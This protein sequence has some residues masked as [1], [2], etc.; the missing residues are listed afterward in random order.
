MFYTVVYLWV[1]SVM[2]FLIRT[3]IGEMNNMISGNNYMCLY[4]KIEN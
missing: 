1:P 4:T 2:K 3:P